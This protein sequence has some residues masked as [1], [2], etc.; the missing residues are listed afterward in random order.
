MLSTAHNQSTNV[1]M[2][3]PKGGCEKFQHHTHSA[4]VIIM[5]V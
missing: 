2:K 4:Y 1:A 5:P 3:N